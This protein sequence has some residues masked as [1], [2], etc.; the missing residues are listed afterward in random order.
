VYFN[1]CEYSDAYLTE[2]TAAILK[3]SPEREH[4]TFSAIIIMVLLLLL[5]MGFTIPFL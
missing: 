3:F 1:S 4:A 5:A 2:I